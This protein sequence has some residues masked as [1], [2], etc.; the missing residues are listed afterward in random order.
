MSIHNEN[1][2]VKIP[3][4]LHLMRLGYGYLSLK[5][6]DW[7]KQTNIFP[8]IF[9]DSLCRINSNL[10]ADD[11]KRVLTDISLQLDNED[12][13]RDF[14]ERLTSQSGVKL[15]DFQNLHNNN[16]HVVTELPCVNGEEGFRPDITL[17]INGMPLVFIEVKKPNNKGGI[18]QERQR[19]QTRS[20]N[21]KF[22]RF[23]NITQ[24]MIFSN[25]QEY[26]QG[27]IEPV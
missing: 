19:M 22:R 11:A 3:A 6:N 5:N 16:F 9:I 14:Y 1:S 8:K 21:P 7:D 26:D 2:R 10:S 25:N 20:K 4:I 24:L 13:G 23:I 27:E 18:E 17:L 12:L 15:I